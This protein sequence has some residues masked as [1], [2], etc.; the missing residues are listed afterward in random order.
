MRSKGRAA[1]TSLRRR[2]SINFPQSR[3]RGREREAKAK[4]E[5]K[6][7]GAREGRR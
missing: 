6:R 5:T 3:K 1:Q 2:A 4:E 7:G